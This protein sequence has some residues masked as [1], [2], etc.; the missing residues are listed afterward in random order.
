MSR[1]WYLFLVL[2]V[3]TMQVGAFAQGISDDDFLALMTKRKLP[4]PQTLD[5][6]S[7]T[8][9]QMRRVGASDSEIAEWMSVTID[10]RL[11]ASN[12]PQ[13][14][15]L[16]NPYKSGSVAD[17]KLRWQ[18]VDNVMSGSDGLPGKPMP[19]GQLGAHLAEAA[20]ENEVGNCCES[21]NV[22]LEALRRA[23]IDA[24]LFNTAIGGGHEFVVIGLAPNADPNDP[25]TWGENARVIDGWIGH[26][27]TPAETFE[28]KHIFNGQH[29]TAEGKPL[30]SDQTSAYVDLKQKKAFDEFG[31]KGLLN[32]TVLD[33][34]SKPVAG[35]TV[36]IS[37]DP[38]Q[39]QTSTAQGICNFKSYPGKLAVDVLPPKD[40]PF[41]AGHGDTYV[42]VRRSISLNI[43]LKKLPADLK[44]TLTS[45]ADGAKVKQADLTVT[46]TVTGG[47]ASEVMLSVGGTSVPVSVQ[48]KQF[49]TKVTL[50]PGETVLQASAGGKQSNTVTVTFGA[51]RSAWDGVWHGRLHLVAR[52]DKGQ[53][54]KDEDGDLTITQK[55]DTITIQSAKGGALHLK[56]DPAN[57]NVA[58]FTDIG[59]TPTTATPTSHGTHKKIITATLRDGHL[60]LT[61]LFELNSFHRVTE[62]DPWEEI[63]TR[64]DGNGEYE[65]GK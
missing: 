39:E 53:Q 43:T 22:A 4:V 57:P 27:L 38:P 32:V 18:A 65:R 63:N 29:T 5:D 24:R 48:D 41:D 6:F 35:V 36:R 45:P 8:V 16:F 34:A 40:S 44:L 47:D 25:S 62:K 12:K 15:S 50:S 14:E 59:P 31:N 23:G 56:L 30:V 7:K 20:W 64:G 3:L 52:N 17:R 26:S 9:A 42:E 28:Q 61:T 13:G 49:S 58:T 54:I 10:Q 33:E 46:G 21:A 60:T 11:E 51:P 55:D 2:V 37:A 1:A 19:D